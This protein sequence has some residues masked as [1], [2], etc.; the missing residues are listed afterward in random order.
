MDGT[1]TISVTVAD[2]SD[3]LRVDNHITS[4]VSTARWTIS[5]VPTGIQTVAMGDNRIELKLYPNPSSDV[6]NISFR[7]QN[8][9]AVTLTVYSSQGVVMQRRIVPANSAKENVLTVDISTYTTGSYFLELKTKD[10]IHS[11][12]FIKKD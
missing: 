11:E 2:T 1:N 8:K 3:L 5:K 4:H 10:F 6:L 12:Q 7:T 9:E